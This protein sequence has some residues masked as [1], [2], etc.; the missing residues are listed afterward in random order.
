M[1]GANGRVF[2]R[3]GRNIYSGQF[4][5]A[6]KKLE[7]KASDFPGTPRL[8][9][10]AVSPNGTKLAFATGG[11]IWTWNIE[12]DTK[13]N[14][15]KVA[16]DNLDLYQLRYPTWS[17]T[18]N[19]LVFQALREQNSIRSQRLYRIN[20]DGT[21]IKQLFKLPTNEAEH[22]TPDWSVN[23]KIVFVLQDD[24]WLINP[25][26]TGETNLTD[27]GENYF[28]P[29]WSPNGTE[30]AVQHQGPN[31]D[32]MSVDDE[33]GIFVVDATTG[34]VRAI[35]GNGDTDDE[36]SSPS[37][38]PDGDWIAFDGYIDGGSEEFTNDIFAVDLDA[39][40]IFE[41]GVSNANTQP[42]EG[43]S[44]GTVPPG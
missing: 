1:P 20:T 33:P 26:G 14:V 24:L 15:T 38:S 17:P 7:V 8:M 32:G 6:G 30:I 19:R 23:N 12:Q 10:V 31:T 16:V 39:E 2:F 36:Y 3:Q 28:E 41:L 29:S 11:A 21:G 25:D 9:D 43:P 22:A 4:E 5:V 35:T 34:D 42:A 27:D 40:N 37:W 44:W 18:G 13:R